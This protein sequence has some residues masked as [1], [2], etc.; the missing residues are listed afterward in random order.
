MKFMLVKTDDGLIGST[1]EDQDAWCRFRRRLD[2]LKPGSWLRMEATSPRNGKHHRKMWALLQLITANSETYDTKERALVAVKLAAGF[3]EPHVDP[4]TGHV[5]KV[6]Q[7]I[8]YESMGQED[9]DRFYAAALHGVITVILP[10]LDENTALRL[11]DEITAGWCS[12]V[13]Y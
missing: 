7:S 13:P 11:L 9:F 3:F 10:Q 5:N 1:P 12:A 2:R 8:A 6:P 4:E